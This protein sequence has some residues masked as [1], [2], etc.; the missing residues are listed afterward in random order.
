MLG[1]DFYD[2]MDELYLKMYSR[3]GEVERSIANKTGRIIN[4][5]F[6]KRYLG[7]KV[8]E[9]YVKASEIYDTSKINKKAMKGVENDS[10]GVRFRLFSER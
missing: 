8:D 9:M 5:N 2:R 7:R 1:D 10:E 4:Y 6:D 3:G